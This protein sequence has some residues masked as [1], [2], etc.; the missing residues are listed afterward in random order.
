MQRRCP[1]QSVPTNYG[2]IAST[3]PTL[4][5]ECEAL[6]LKETTDGSDALRSPYALRLL[7]HSYR[8]QGKQS[9]ARK[10]AEDQLAKPTKAMQHPTGQAMMQLSLAELE[11]A[12]KR[13]DRAAHL[14]NE[15]L[16]AFSEMDMPS[17]EALC[18]LALAGAASANERH[19]DA[20][21]FAKDALDR[22]QQ[23]DDESQSTRGLGRALLALA[24]AEQALQDF[25][26]A[27]RSTEKS[28]EVFKFGKEEVW[29]A[30]CVC[31][32]FGFRNF[33]RVGMESRMGG[34]DK[35]RNVCVVCKVSTHLTCM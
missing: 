15:A 4:R 25:A 17:Y 9:W 34:H 29:P 32:C 20:A 28:L 13:Q 30:G 24:E 21:E 14:A 26:A 7:L 23:E 5:Q 2:G 1:E 10:L 31:R 33:K 3:Y 19:G 27:D 12:D 8:C 11:L 22:F 6:L 16:A 35:G 18:L